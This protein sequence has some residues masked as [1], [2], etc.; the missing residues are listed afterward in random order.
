ML[1]QRA[2][3]L[4]QELYKRKKY[5]YLYNKAQNFAVFFSW[6]DQLQLCLGTYY[7]VKQSWRRMI[8]PGLHRFDPGKAEPIVLLHSDTSGV[9]LMLLSQVLPVD[10]LPGVF[11]FACG[12][13]IYVHIA[14][15]AM[16]TR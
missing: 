13:D 16:L 15:P 12:W 8:R 2:S 7:R 5:L 4:F 10:N 6:K 14:V 11:R 1:I 9:V 3:N